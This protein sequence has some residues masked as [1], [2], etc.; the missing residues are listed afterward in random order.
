MVA[1]KPTVVVLGAGVTGLTTALLL[2][3]SQKYH[4]TVL[5]KHMPGEYSI[6]YVSSGLLMSP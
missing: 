4:V 3:R 6:E 5:A 2:A 1:S